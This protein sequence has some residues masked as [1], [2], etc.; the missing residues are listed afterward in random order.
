MHV[1]SLLRVNDSVLRFKY[2]ICPV[3]VRWKSN[4]I[5]IIPLPKRV[6]DWVG[7]RL[8]LRVRGSYLAL[9]GLYKIYTHAA[10]ALKTETSLCKIARLLVSYIRTPSWQGRC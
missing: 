3:M 1:N 4:I 2:P 6:R 5:I 8:G 9:P 7:I 10:A